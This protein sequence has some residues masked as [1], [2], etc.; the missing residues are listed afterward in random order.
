MDILSRY[1]RIVDLHRTLTAIQTS[2]SHSKLIRYGSLI[3]SL[4][5]QMMTLCLAI[6]LQCNTLMAPWSISNNAQYA[7]PK[8][9]GNFI[10]KVYCS[11]LKYPASGTYFCHDFLITKFEGN[12]CVCIS[13]NIGFF[14]LYPYRHQPQKSSIGRAL[15]FVWGTPAVLICTVHF[16][17]LCI[18]EWCS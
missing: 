17:M 1:W 14:F 9:L 8:R 5:L 6:R 4:E 2:S 13:S 3:S 12:I 10:I 15:V 18:C 7:T 16:H 11:I